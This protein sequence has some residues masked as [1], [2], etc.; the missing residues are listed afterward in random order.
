MSYH[1]YSIF[2]EMAKASQQ[3]EDSSRATT[4]YCEALKKKHDFL[5][6]RLALARLYLAQ[7][8]VTS[9]D[10]ECIILLRID[11]DNEQAALVSVL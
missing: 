2:F 4:Y 3:L 5:E 10:Q 11:Q 1:H 8:D 9:C 7:G 6:A